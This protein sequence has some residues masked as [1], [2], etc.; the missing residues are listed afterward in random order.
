[1]DQSTPSL[2]NL[3]NGWQHEQVDAALNFLRTFSFH[4]RTLSVHFITE[5]I[6][7]HKLSICIEAIASDLS[8]VEVRVKTVAQDPHIKTCILAME[9]IEDIYRTICQS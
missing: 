2:D 9:E 8:E 7:V 3:V 4:D 6:Q 5:I 1:M